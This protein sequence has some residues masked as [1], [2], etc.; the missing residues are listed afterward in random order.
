MLHVSAMLLLLFEDL[1]EEGADG[2]QV[3]PQ[4]VLERAGCCLAA[5]LQ[6]LGADRHLAGVMHKLASQPVLALAGSAQQQ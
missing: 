1:K 3:W 2:H 5:A 4:L 6:P